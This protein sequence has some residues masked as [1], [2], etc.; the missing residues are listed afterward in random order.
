MSQQPYIIDDQLL[1]KYLSGEAL[2]EEAIQVEHWLEADP[3]NKAIFDQIS[4]AWNQFSAGEPHQLPDKKLFWNSVKQQLHPQRTQSASE[5][6][7]LVRIGIA[8][9]FLLIISLLIRYFNTAQNNPSSVTAELVQRKTSD[10]II[11]DTLSD[12]SVVTLATQSGISYP[13]QFK[14]NRTITLTG[15][16]S[17]DV[18][19][20][21]ADPFTVIAGPV[22]IKVL[23]TNFFV[24]QDSLEIK[25]NVHTGKVRMYGGGDSLTLLP[26]QQGIYDI[27]KKKIDLVEP[28][29]KPLSKAVKEMNFQNT[30]LI[31]VTRSLEA[32][33]GV[34][35]VYE[36]RELAHCTISASFDKQSL[37]YILEVIAATLNIQFRKDHKTVYLSGKSCE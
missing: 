7:W 2:P 10:N 33:F 36:N 37:D 26:N 31:E 21:A 24:Y 25:V 1:A 35:F 18:R 22:T 6:I 4:A 29:V 9:G 16:A 20:I 14:G 11:N 32:H 19:H 23:G 28:Y 34:E 30:S 27:A 17:F 3:N 12:G 13:A 5:K 15:M 8:A